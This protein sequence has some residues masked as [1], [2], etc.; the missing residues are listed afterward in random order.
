[1][2]LAILPETFGDLAPA[3]RTVLSH[4]RH[5][6]LIGGQPEPAADGRTFES[7]DPATG[8]VIA[9][10]ALAGP[11]DVDRAVGE[12]RR[13]Y[14]G[15]W[16]R[17]RA[18]DRART[19][20]RLA[21]LL[22]AN[23]DELA[24]LESL[25]QG[26]PLR[27][28]CAVDVPRAVEHIRDLAVWP[29]R[30]DGRMIPVREAETLCYTL[31]QPA[32]VCAQIVPWTFP[33]LG[34]VWK[35][36]AALAAGCTTVLKPA[37]ETPLTALRLGELALEAGIPAGVLNVLTG[38]DATGGALATH[39]GVDLVSCTGWTHAGYALDRHSRKATR[40]AR[41]AHAVKS[42]SI[43][44]PDADLG[45]A[46]RGTLL[47]LESGSG[48]ECG[49]PARLYVPRER[50]ED[51]LEEAA[52]AACELEL[53]PLV[54]GA[55]RQRVL[56]RIAASE[57]N[58]AR[59]VAGGGPSERGGYFVEPTV[60]AADDRALLARKEIP[61][62]VLAVLPYMSPDEIAARDQE[63][64]TALWTRDLGRAHLLAQRLRGRCVFINTWD[65]AHPC[66]P[67]GGQAD[68]GLEGERR[69]EA[70]EAYV[71]PRIVR[72]NLGASDD[73]LR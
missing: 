32:G 37:L 4:E 11:E 17:M 52:A 14:E 1:M 21:D 18:A 3:A 33:L 71:E 25:D 55:Q 31:E 26:R 13:A 27:F 69:R 72:T 58:G 60:L 8:H 12:A 51:A 47:G 20:V 24:E 6:L 22:D 56:R 49:A 30:I 46:I 67:F 5:D 64:V 44:L 36:V 7:R 10:V 54:S 57:A 40:G 19:L 16:S 35:A 73:T 61:G 29:P 39:P 53:G 48:Q 59:V 65:S 45:A 2:S 9:T 68:P 41:V 38:D 42:S 50:Y 28:T 23:A 43:V 63:L 70:V 15:A 66:P 62:P 34:A